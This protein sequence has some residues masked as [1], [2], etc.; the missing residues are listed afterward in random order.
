MFGRE[1]RLF[2]LFGFSVGVDW[3]WLIIAVLICRTG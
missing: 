1:I 2:K 3:S